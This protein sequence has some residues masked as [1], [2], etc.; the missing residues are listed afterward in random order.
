VR[1][2]KN[3][4]RK[5]IEVDK[6]KNQNAV[7]TTLAILAVCV[8]VLLGAAGVNA[9][10]GQAA[11]DHVQRSAIGTSFGDARLTHGLTPGD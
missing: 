11:Q 8:S 5:E 10:A 2:D 9:Y 7:R 6:N 3:A 1:E 4:L